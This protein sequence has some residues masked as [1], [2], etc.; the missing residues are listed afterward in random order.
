MSLSIRHFVAPALATVCLFVLPTVA[1]FAQQQEVKLDPKLP[2]YKKVSG[3]SGTLKS[4][5][6]DTMNNLVS[7]W[8]G[9][10]KKLYP[11]V[12]TEIDGKDL[13]TQSQLWW[14]APRPSG[15]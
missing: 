4:V 3:V 14:P 9:E 7:L 8:A 12:K 11:G 1:A 6:S 10:F 13:R 15:R 5:G 2:D